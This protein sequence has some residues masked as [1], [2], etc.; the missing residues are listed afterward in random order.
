MLCHHTLPGKCVIRVVL[1][2]EQM[3]RK[4]KSQTGEPKGEYLPQKSGVSGFIRIPSWANNSADRLKICNMACNGRQTTYR[5]YWVYM[6]RLH[7]KS[8][9]LGGVAVLDSS[10]FLLRA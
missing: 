9:C 10:S 2:G 8:I 3:K 1:V 5:P 4:P 6:G 7:G